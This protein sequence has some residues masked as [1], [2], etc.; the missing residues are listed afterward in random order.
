M[1]LNFGLWSVRAAVSKLFVRNCSL[2]I[3]GVH[4]GPEAF[5]VQDIKQFMAAVRHRILSD[6]EC[7]MRHVHNETDPAFSANFM[8]SVIFQV[9][10]VLYHRPTNRVK[11]RARLAKDKFVPE[12]VSAKDPKYNE[13][14]ANQCNSPRG[15]A[16]C[17]S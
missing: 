15:V 2:S 13:K 10:L 5:H 4:D 14:N 8:L 3:K 11:A 12:A 16:G 7:T 17:H 6:F 9:C 1:Y